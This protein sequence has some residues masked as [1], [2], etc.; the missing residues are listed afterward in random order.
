MVL[1]VLVALLVKIGMEIAVFHALVVKYGLNH[2]RLA[3]ASQDINGMELIALFHA[4][5]GKSQ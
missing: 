2:L 5:M 4:P 1:N 3:C